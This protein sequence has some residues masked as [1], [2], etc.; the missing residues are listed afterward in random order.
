MGERYEVVT[1]D[2]YPGFGCAKSFDARCAAVSSVRPCQTTPWSRLRD[3][4]HMTKSPRQ[5]VMSF[6]GRRELA[7]LCRPESG[8]PRARAEVHE[9]DRGRG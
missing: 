4:V 6:G 9:V 2:T 8:Q 5:L 7:S 1:A 3:L